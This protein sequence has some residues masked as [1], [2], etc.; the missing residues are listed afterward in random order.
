MEIFKLVGS[1]FIDSEK[2]NESIQ[3]TDEKAG[4]LGQTLVNGAKTAG[5]FALGL[6]TA[7]AAGATALVGLAND[8]AGT[9]DEIDKMSQKMGLSKEG[10]QEWR[11]VMGQNGMDISTLNT[12]MKTLVNQMESAAGGSKTA[13]SYFEQLGI[14]IYDSN[15]KLKDQETML[16]EAIYALADVEDATLKSAL[17]TDLFGKAGTEM[18]PM[19]NSGSEGMKELTERSHDLGLIMSDEAVGA[20]VL[21]GD[22]MDD[23][24]QSFGAIVAKIGVEVMPIIQKMLD[25]VLEHMPEIQTVIGTVFDAIS[26]VVETAGKV[27][28]WLFG[29]FKKNMPAIKDFCVRAFEDISL[30]W[31]EHLQPCFQAIGDFIQNK[32]AP[33]FEWLF[34]HFIGPRIQSFVVMVKELW[35]N[36]L[37]PILTNII[38]FITNVFSGNFSGAFENLIAILKGIWNGIVAIIKRPINEAIGIINSF[39][40]GLNKIKIPDWVPGIG[41]KGIN[42]SK[43]PLLAKGGNVVQKGNVIVGDAGPELLE[44]PAGAKV[45][46]LSNGKRQAFGTDNLERKLDTL[47]ALMQQMVNSQYGVYINGDALVG[48]LIPSIDRGLGRLAI[49]NGRGA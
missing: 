34:E 38:D 8:A 23:A 48:E 16:N 22:T 11:Y 31:K 44:L 3:K 47:I 45:T 39:I 28:G 21:L 35:N 40:S 12:G 19:L 10:F 24:K 13:S 42:I 29:E 2:A 17:A 20:G 41:G 9:A 30:F 6:G 27:L 26:I 18:L 25:W 7:A 5:K 33:I 1:I 43:I 32:L 49:R 14:S 46:P 4:G 36:S 37:K 15:G